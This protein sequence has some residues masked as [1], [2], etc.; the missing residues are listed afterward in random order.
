VVIEFPHVTL[1]KFPGIWDITSWLQYW[2]VQAAVENG[3]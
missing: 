3:H 1:P 2:Q